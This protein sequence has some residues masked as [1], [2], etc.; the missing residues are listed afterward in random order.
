MPP[1]TCYWSVLMLCCMGLL[2]KLPSCNDW[3]CDY[4]IYAV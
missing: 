4:E 1:V 3:T 2:G